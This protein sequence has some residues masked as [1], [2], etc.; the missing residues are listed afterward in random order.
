MPTMP[1]RRGTMRAR[2]SGLL[3]AGAS[4]PLASIAVTLRAAALAG[5]AALLLWFLSDVVLLVFAAVLIGV[6]LRGLAGG[7]H[8]LT[9]LSVHWCLAA[10]TIA[11]AAVAA[12]LAWR[13]GPR[14]V[15]EGHDMA[16]QIAGWME[17]VRQQSGAGAGL[18]HMLSQH[19]QGT[20][21]PGGAMLRPGLDMLRSTLGSMASVLVVV[22]AGLYFAIAPAMYL[23]GLARVAPVRYRPRA[24]RIMRQVAHTLR[25]WSLGQAIDMAVVGLLSG[26]GLA[27]AGIPLALALALL[28]GL[29]TFVPY[30]GAIAAS[31]PAII[32]AS[33]LG[34]SKVFWVIGVFLVCHGIEGYVVAPLVQRRTAA[35]PPALTI[36]AMLIL[37]ATYGP[38]GLILGTPVVAA[39]LVVVRE[40]YVG[41]VLG[42]RAPDQ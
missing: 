26:V 20:G 28:A 33:T 23:N 30:F 34:W 24:R 13:V 10:T 14:L 38:L 6:I 29:F 40:A 32:V 3:G 19:L 17:K 42:D 18:T 9:G 7:L 31:V 11:I 15:H 36:M 8:R 2:A 27:L 16:G 37:G 39:L 35:L 41:D 5:A 25:S 1:R 12:A 21:G 22:V 4:D